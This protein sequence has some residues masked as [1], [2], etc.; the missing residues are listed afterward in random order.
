M[1]KDIIYS[2]NKS[3][4]F[5]YVF[6]TLVIFVVINKSRLIT[7]HNIVSL[8]ITLV[9][10][11]SLVHRQL[12]NDMS[13]MYV[14][15]NKLKQIQIS[16]YPFLKNDIH[17]IECIHRLQSLSSINRIK[18]N[19]IL[20]HIN[21]FF[22]Y[23]EMSKNRNLRPSDLYVSAKDNA[24][25]ALNALKSFVIDMNK[26]PYL[27]SDRT[28]SKNLFISDNN[29][30][31]SCREIIKSRLSIYLTEMEKKINNDWN[32]DN[33]NIFSKPIYTDDPEAIMESDVLHSEFYDIY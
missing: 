17:V 29:S 30:V 25:R 7:M 27:D 2:F 18:F 12:L 11:Y 24:S 5:Y 4:Y 13:A 10:I 6:A 28:I 14:Q 8:C 20:H 1:I 31:Y 9:I 21:T 16:K 23:Y 19:T 3:D 15:N 26:Y 22:K 32:N 33:I